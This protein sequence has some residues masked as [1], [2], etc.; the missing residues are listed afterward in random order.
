M[1]KVVIISG[2]VLVVITLLCSLCFWTQT[3][4]WIGYEKPNNNSTRQLKTIEVDVAQYDLD[5]DNNEVIYSKLFDYSEVKSKIK[6]YKYFIESDTYEEIYTVEDSEPDPFPDP[7]FALSSD[8][9]QI[10]LFNTDRRKG[11][12]FGEVI[13]IASQGSGWDISEYSILDPDWEG[14]WRRDNLEERKQF[15]MKSCKE[16]INS[17][18]ELDIVEET[19]FVMSDEDK[20]AFPI[21]NCFEGLGMNVYNKHKFEDV[22]RRFHNQLSIIDKPE[23]N[24]NTN[25]TDSKYLIIEDEVKD[26]KFVGYEGPAN[27]AGSPVTNYKIYFQSDTPFILSNRSVNDPFFPNLS[28]TFSTP[29][30]IKLPDSLNF[31]TKNDKLVFHYD[32]DLYIFE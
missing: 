31:A 19:F 15:N 4:F 2:V 9:Q 16:Y 11:E 32:S 5:I 10:Y 30:G 29:R 17:H 24:I 26:Y 6:I 8:F 13:R 14:E 18:D 23:E 3:R 25:I 27:L 7:F 28:D 22:K 21:A 20:T 1:K 12:Y